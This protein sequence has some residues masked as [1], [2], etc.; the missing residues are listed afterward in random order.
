MSD[1]AA[2]EVIRQH[3][4]HHHAD[5]EG[6]PICRFECWK[7]TTRRIRKALEKVGVKILAG[8]RDSELGDVKGVV[9][10]DGVRVTFRVEFL[11]TVK[12]DADE[13][14]GL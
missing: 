12:Q 5:D 9:E 1:D 13:K 6:C 14:R 3:N 11:P 8:P 4:E 2:Y 10:E 7:N